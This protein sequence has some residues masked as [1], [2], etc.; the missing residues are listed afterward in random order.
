MAKS[1]PS[2]FPST[3][4]PTPNTAKRPLQNMA[5]IQA[6]RIIHRILQG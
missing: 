4:A 2:F 5:C 6:P 3:E 1:Q